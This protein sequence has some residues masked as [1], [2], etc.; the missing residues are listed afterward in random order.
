MY[1]FSIFQCS[2]LHFLLQYQCQRV[3]L[4]FLISIYNLAPNINEFICWQVL[5][6]LFY[7]SELFSFEINREISKLKFLN[8]Y[9][10]WLVSPPQHLQRNH[11][12]FFLGFDN[13]LNILSVTCLVV[14]TFVLQKKKISKS[15][16]YKTHY[17]FTHVDSN[18]VSE[19][20]KQ[21]I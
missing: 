9:L 21:S 20:E 3:R 16:T 14:S 6:L 18:I 8:D 12:T 17:F 11:I 5:D 2:P 15:I 10:F 19:I 4:Q 13:D 7:G 1:G